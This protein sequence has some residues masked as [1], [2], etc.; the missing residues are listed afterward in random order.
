MP[1][2][3]ETVYV[4]PFIVSSEHPSSSRAM[5]WEST[6]NFVETYKT[7]QLGPSS[8]GFSII[9]TGLGSSEE[10]IVGRIFNSVPVL[11]SNDLSGQYKELGVALTE[12][13]RV[14]EGDDWNIE[15][16]VY[17]AARYVASELKQFSVPT[18]QIFNHG[19]K[20]VVFNWTNG[21]TSLYLTISANRLSALVSSPERIQKRVEVDFSQMPKVLNLVVAS[22][23]ENQ[24]AIVFVT[25][26]ASTKLL[27]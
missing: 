25:S 26:F 10:H 4:Q 21:S 27:P 8:T 9:P 17:E 15:G 22:V 6:D 24:P 7:L 11:S 3:I 18:P 14:E 12:M 23:N 2:H 20:S 13:S 19:P 16:P 1:K 5:T